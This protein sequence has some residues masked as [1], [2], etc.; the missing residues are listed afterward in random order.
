MSRGDL[1]LDDLEQHRRWIATE[2]REGAMASWPGEIID[3]VDLTGAMLAGALLVETT[4]VRCP[5]VAAE[6]SRAVAGGA[7]FVGASAAGARFVKA[8]LESAVFDGSDLRAATFLKADLGGASLKGCWLAGATFDDARC[9]GANFAGAQ[10]RAASLVRTDF[11]GGDLAG[12]DLADAHLVETRFDQETRLDGVVGLERC[13]VE[14]ILVGPRRLEQDAGTAWLRAQATRPAWSV[15]D[16]ETWL[17]SKMSGRV[18]VLLATLGVDEARMR[19]VAAEL[20]HVFDAPGHAAA[21]YRRVL[22]R[23]LERAMVGAAGAY[24]GSVRQ[25]FRLPLWPAVEFV[26]NEDKD[27]TAWGVEFVGGPPAVPPDLATIASQEWSFERLKQL[28]ATVLIEEEW[29]YDREAVFTF[30]GVAVRFRG[31]FDVGLLQ[32]WEAVG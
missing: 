3:G 26:V 28:A 10:L 12:A 6:F 8:Q 20:G 11:S 21:E 16:L 2:G 1:I 15:A 19:E 4:F 9:V 30:S 27:G 5:I 22:G 13:V 7:S 32:A 14:S 23:P 17:V 25:T 24:A 29:S 18:E 31:R